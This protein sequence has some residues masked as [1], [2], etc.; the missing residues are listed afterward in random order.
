MLKILQILLHSLYKLTEMNVIDGFQNIINEC[1]N[2]FFVIG[3]T[4][5][6]KSYVIKFVVSLASLFF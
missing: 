6:C 5:I 1:L 4:S 3:D 2:Y